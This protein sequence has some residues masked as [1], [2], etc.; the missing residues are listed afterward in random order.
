MF[1]FQIIFA[2]IEVVMHDAISATHHVYG[3]KT[4]SYSGFGITEDAVVNV[5][6]AECPLNDP[7][8]L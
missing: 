5:H 3:D 1:D 6:H 2:K 7:D 8:T 4:Y